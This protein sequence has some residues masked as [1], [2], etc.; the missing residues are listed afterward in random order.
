MA[1]QFTGEAG[2]G[3]AHLLLDE[4]VP[5]AAH[6]G[7]AAVLLD[8]LFDRPAAAQVIE[9]VALLAGQHVLGDQGRDHIHCHDGAVFIDKPHAVGIAVKRHT[10]IVRAFTDHRLQRHE[11]LRLERIGLVVGE[12]A[13]QLLED[14]IDLDQAIQH[15]CLDRAHRVGHISRNLDR[16]RDL[17]M[18]PD[19][20]RVFS[21]DVVLAD[22]AGGRGGRIERLLVADPLDIHDAGGAA[23][24][25]RL[26]ARHLDAVPF[27]RIVGGR[28][29]HPAIGLEAAAPEIGHGCG[30]QSEIDHIGALHDGAV[31]KGLEEGG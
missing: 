1:R 3:I 7:R 9:D 22:G 28:D 18:R 30:G 12:G 25:H 29:H 24:R 11:R 16:P 21:G 17:G 14:R 23:D 4:G 26:G 8:H 15:A 13:V 31:R 27:A 20:R 19:V 2:V 10:E 6:Q 5:H